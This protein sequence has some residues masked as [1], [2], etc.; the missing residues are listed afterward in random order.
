[1]TEQE[2][3]SKVIKQMES[4]GYYCLKLIRTNKNGI[5]DLLCIK[6]NVVLFIEIKR[7]GGRLSE[8]QKFRIKELS[9]NGFICMVKFA[10]EQ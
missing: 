1:M 9:E 8:L 7:K 3:Q 4:E 6:P 10:P 5:P 2:Y